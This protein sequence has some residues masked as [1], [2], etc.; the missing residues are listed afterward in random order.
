MIR[1][2][3]SIHTSGTLAER[4]PHISALSA[5][6]E[7]QNRKRKERERKKDAF[8]GRAWRW[9]RLSQEGS[10]CWT[11]A[12]IPNVWSW[13][14]YG[15]S[16]FVQ[17]AGPQGPKSVWGTQGLAH[18]EHRLRR[19]WALESLSFFLVRSTQK[20]C[21]KWASPLLLADVSYSYVNDWTMPLGSKCSPMIGC[22]SI[23]VSLLWSLFLR[24]HL[25]RLESD[26]LKRKAV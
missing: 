13:P 19:S 8:S 10:P 4:S 18:W 2:Q 12:P 1:D 6:Q 25:G 15:T 26:S 17:V 5:P 7:E 3:N 11:T 24:S 9:K 16:Y 23:R 20:P 21:L 22:T 14:L